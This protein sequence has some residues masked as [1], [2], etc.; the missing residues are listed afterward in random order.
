[1]KSKV[2]SR[3]SV[4]PNEQMPLLQRRLKTKPTLILL[5]LLFLGNVF[6]FILWLIPN[7]DEQKGGNEQV[8]AV[9]ETIITRQQWMATM[10]ER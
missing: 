10:E 6:W 9:N 3:P 8:A 1:M 5:A 4:Q 7:N 2:N